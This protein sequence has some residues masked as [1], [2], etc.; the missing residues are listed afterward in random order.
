MR[1]SDTGEPIRDDQ[2]RIRYAYGD[3]WGST[4]DLRALREQ[5]AE[6][7]NFHLA[8]NGHEVRVDHRSFRDQGID[9]LTPSSHVGLPA[10]S[11]QERGK[12]ADRVAQAEAERQDRA[13]ALAARPESHST[14]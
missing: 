9:G 6:Y 7:Q 8:L 4:E 2:G 3:R 14:S 5:W 10:P 12:P 11:M 1:D 13:R